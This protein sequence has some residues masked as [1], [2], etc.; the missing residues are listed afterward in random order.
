MKT[1]SKIWYKVTSPDLTA[2]YDKKT[3]YIE[4]TTVSLPIRDNP[5]LCS[6]DVLHASASVM[7]ALKY[8]E[9]IP[10]TIS[11]VTG[12]PVVVYTDKAGFFKLKV[13]RNIPQ[14]EYDELLGFRYSEAANPVNPCAITP[15]TIDDHIVELLKNW[16]SVR[17]SVGDSVWDSIAAYIW[18]SVRGSVWDSVAT[19]IGSLFPGAFPVPYPYQSGVDLWKM[20]L[21]PV[22]VGNE[23]RLYHPVK[24]G[25]AKLIYSLT[26]ANKG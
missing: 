7:D 6:S 16:A 8:F 20:G 14:S 13:L 12:K 5:R 17:Y 1:K 3:I 21:I 10:C 4:G 23:W 18:A 15:P 2:K 25:K 22:R 24:G 19:Y 26:E 11:T 9:Q